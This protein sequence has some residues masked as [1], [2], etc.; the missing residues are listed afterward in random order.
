MTTTTTTNTI[1]LHDA[2]ITGNITELNAQIAAGADVNTTDSDGYTPIH[3]AT[4][5][6]H[7]DIVNA[8]IAAGAKQ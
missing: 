5:N 6:R 3:W 7:L 4:S 1:T 2:A 8:L